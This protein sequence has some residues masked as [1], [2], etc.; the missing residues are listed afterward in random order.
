MH[1]VE[2]CKKHSAKLIFPS[3]VVYGDIKHKKFSEKLMPSPT[4]PY[5]LSKFLTEN[6]FYFYSKMFNL[7]IIILRIFNVYGAG[8]K[9]LFLIPKLFSSLQKKVFLNSISYKR[10]FVYI[11]DVIYAFIKAISVKKNFSI[12][13]VGSGKSYSIKQLIKKIFKITKQQLNIHYQ[14]KILPG[15]PAS[16]CAD[17]LKAKKVLNW[18]PKV[19]I[20]EGLKKYFKSIA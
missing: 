6:I 13:N 3:S 17:T 16:V 8:Q 18:S 4:N 10:D 9:K 5:T 20:D 12:I 2:Y 11:D 15:E 19:K 14:N 1:A 7:K